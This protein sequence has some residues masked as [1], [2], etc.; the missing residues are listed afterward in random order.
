MC[1]RAAL[2]AAMDCQA[3]MPHGAGRDEPCVKPVFAGV[4]CYISTETG[5]R[6]NKLGLKG[7]NCPLEL[8]Q[9]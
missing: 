2:D 3:H 1:N 5:G 9:K 8:G 6:L 4:D 7:L